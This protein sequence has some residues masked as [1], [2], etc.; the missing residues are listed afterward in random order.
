M[1]IRQ[2][3]IKGIAFL[4]RN[5]K[6]ITITMPIT[7]FKSKTAYNS[8]NA[9]LSFD[10]QLLVKVRLYMTP[11]HDNTSDA[12]LQALINSTVPDGEDITAEVNAQIPSGGE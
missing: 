12:D 10:P 7:R 5:P 9:P 2:A 4:I 11:T 3:I 1:T 8:E 6:I